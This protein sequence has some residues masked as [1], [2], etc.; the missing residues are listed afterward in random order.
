MTPHI[1]THKDKCKYANKCMHAKPHTAL[2]GEAHWPCVGTP[3]DK[4]KKARC[5]PCD[6]EGEPA[7][8]K[9]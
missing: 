1:C 6:E 3:C 4:I 2:P 9:I 5:V 8:G 7:N